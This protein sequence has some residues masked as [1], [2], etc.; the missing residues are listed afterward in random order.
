MEIIKS[1]LDPAQYVE[2]VKK[3]DLIILHHTVG[4][5]AQSTINYWKSDSQRIGTAFIVERDGK[6]YQTFPEHF[7]A[8]HVGSKVGNNIDKR[9]IGIEIASEGGLTKNN[10]ELYS[11]GVISPRTKFTQPYVDLGYVWRGFQYFDAYNDAQ[12]EAV[13]ELVDYLCKKFNIPKNLPDNPKDYDKKYYTHKGI[14]GH[15]H[16]RPDKSDVH[17]NFP[18][19]RLI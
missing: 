15:A 14:C 18:W 7:W 13:I 16:I 5:T 3:K 17:P 4:G 1:F 6:I 11:F 9:S 10:G 19:E 12:I 2:E 8:Y